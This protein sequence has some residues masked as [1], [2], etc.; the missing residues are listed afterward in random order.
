MIALHDEKVTEREWL[1]LKSTWNSTMNRSNNDLIGQGKQVSEGL[2]KRLAHYARKRLA[3]CGWGEAIET[4]E[5][6]VDAWNNYGDSAE[7]ANYCVKFYNETG[8]AM[9]VQ[10]ISIRKGWPD[11][12][13]GIF[14]DD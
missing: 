4:C 14:L 3:D 2:A 12:D 1:Q 7:D 8:S 6:T 13:H 11:M 9:G 5:A 10:G